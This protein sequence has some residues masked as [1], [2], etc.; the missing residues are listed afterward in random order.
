LELEAALE[1]PFRHDMKSQ[2]TVR[3]QLQRRK[4]GVGGRSQKEGG[5]GREEG[6]GKR[7]KEGGRREER[8]GGGGGGGGGGEGGGGA[9]SSRANGIYRGVGTDIKEVSSSCSQCQYQ[10]HIPKCP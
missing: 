9:I 3:D 10:K 5:V 8:G 1:L 2:A 6:G 7:E 4:K